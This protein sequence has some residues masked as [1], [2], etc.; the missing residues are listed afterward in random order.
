MCVSVHCHVSAC[1]S[2]KLRVKMIMSHPHGFWDWGPG[3]L[4]EQYS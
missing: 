4:E 2:I 1:N 3:P